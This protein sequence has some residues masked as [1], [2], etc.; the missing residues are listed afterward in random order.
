[1]EDNTTREWDMVHDRPERAKPEGAADDA[2]VELAIVAGVFHARSGYEER[3]AAT[4]A[5]YVVL[6]RMEDG[7]RNIDLVAS[8]TVR[9]LFMVW[10]KWESHSHRQAHF[11]GTAARRLAGEV[12]D[13]V[14]EPPQ[15]DVFDA[16]SAHDLA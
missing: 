2:E 8:M 13:L 1:M 10:E 9:G 6:S 4:L 11:E 16:I 3:L 14:A 15:F 5:R 7:C 12:A